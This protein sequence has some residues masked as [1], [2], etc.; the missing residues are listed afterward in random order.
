MFKD[1]FIVAVKY[2]DSIL[3]EDGDTVTLPFDSEYSILL[4]NLNS[5]RASI[6]IT[7]DGEDILNGNSLVLKPNSVLDL[8][9]FLED[10]DEVKKK[11]KFIHKTKDIAD[12]RGDRIDDGLIRIEFAYEKPQTNWYWKVYGE[13]LGTG[14]YWKTY[15]K[16]DTSYYNRGTSYSSVKDSLP[17]TVMMMNSIVNDTPSDD[18]GMTV[19]GSD[20]SQGFVSTY[21]N[22]LEPSQVIILKLKGIT[23]DGKDIKKPITTKDKITCPTCGKTSKSDAKFCYN[24]GTAL[25]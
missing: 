7:I 21:I 8:K 16:D 18:E 17:G 20:T 5:K 11:F 23:K 6:N 10:D 4:K 12:Y 9:G 14:W 3:R 19:K 15:Y 24:C 13:E 1:N 25:T 22:E 2:N